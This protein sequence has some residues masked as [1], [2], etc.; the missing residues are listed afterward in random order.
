MFASTSHTVSPGLQSTSYSA[1]NFAVSGY[2]AFRPHAARRQFHAR[3]TGPVRVLKKIFADWHPSPREVASLLAYSD[4]Q[5]A[6]NVLS[7]IAALRDPDREDRVRLIYQIYRVLSSLFVDRQNQRNWL[8]AP[9]SFLNGRAPLD[10]MIADRIPGMIL[11]RDLVDRL[12][13]R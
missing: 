10:V 2:E 7:G 4:P 12:A 8:R 1:A 13:G 6:D 5:I 3:I 11:V 9:S